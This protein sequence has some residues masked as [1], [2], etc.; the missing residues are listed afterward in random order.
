MFKNLMDYYIMP[1]RRGGLC[2]KYAVVYKSKTGFAKKYAEWISEELGA[3]IFEANKIN[4]TKLEKYDGIVYGG[5]LHAVGIIGVKLITENMDRLKGKKL[6][7]FATGASPFSERVRDEVAGANFKPD[8]KQKIGFFYLRGGFDY[9]KLPPFDKF[10]MTLMKWT[11]RIKK[12]AGKK[13]SSDEIGMNIAFDKPADFTNKKYIQPVVE[14]MKL[15]MLYI[16]TK[17]SKKLI[18]YRQEISY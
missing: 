5:S 15:R 11:I 6:A 12:A 14:Y 9:N 3:D 16:L 8:Q 17:Y 7:V 4:I 13:L 1:W 2:L 10:L 18:V